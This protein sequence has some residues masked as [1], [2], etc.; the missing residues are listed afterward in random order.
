MKTECVDDEDIDVEEYDQDNKTTPNSMS[1][2]LQRDQIK[3]ATQQP[4][5][6]TNTGRSTENVDQTRKVHYY[7][8][9]VDFR[10]DILMKPP[11]AKSISLY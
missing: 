11:G 2:D 6:V 9:R 3:R 10:G 4:N 5:D 1:P 7:Q 8:D